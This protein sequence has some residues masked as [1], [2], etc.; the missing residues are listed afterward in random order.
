MKVTIACIGSAVLVVAVDLPSAVWTAARSTV[1]MVSGVFSQM[2]PP[3]PIAFNAGR[4]EVSA[5][6]TDRLSSEWPLL[7]TSEVEAPA[8]RQIRSEPLKVVFWTTWAAEEREYFRS[9][10]VAFLTIAY[11]KSLKGIG[12]P[13]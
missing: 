13:T 1:Q 9:C 3:L 8:G 10:V 7:P 11:P 4:P 6:N 5:P 2:I 12:S